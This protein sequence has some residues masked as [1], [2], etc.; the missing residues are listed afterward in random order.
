MTQNIPSPMVVGERWQF[1][2]TINLEDNIQ[3]HYGGTKHT[4][5]VEVCEIDSL[6]ILEY[7]ETK[8]C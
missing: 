5:L 4:S 1:C 8:T 3:H 7:R 6:V 2:N